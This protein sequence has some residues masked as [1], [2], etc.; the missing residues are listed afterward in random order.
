MPAAHFVP[1]QFMA[2][3]EKRGCLEAL[4]RQPLFCAERV[5][6]GDAVHTRIICQIEERS[7]PAPRADHIPRR[8][9]YR[10]PELLGKFIRVGGHLVPGEPGGSHIGD[11]CRVGARRSVLKGEGHCPIGSGDT[12]S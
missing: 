1:A 7:R 6:S 12:G 11:F 10:P 5:N 8:L 4:L 2:L 3:Q 9:I